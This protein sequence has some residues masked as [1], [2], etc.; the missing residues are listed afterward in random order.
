MASENTGTRSAILFSGPRRML[1]GKTMWNFSQALTQRHAPLRFFSDGPVVQWYC[2]DG[3]HFLGLLRRAKAYHRLQYDRAIDEDAAPCNVEHVVPYRSEIDFTLGIHCVMHVL[4][5]AV[6][7]GVTPFSS[8]DIVDDMH[9]CI[10][11]LQNSSCAISDH[12]PE[13]LHGR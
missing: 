6:K 10:Q 7:W 1:H 9:V 4:S 8:T 13:F 2:F 12:I 5:L 11:S 3:L